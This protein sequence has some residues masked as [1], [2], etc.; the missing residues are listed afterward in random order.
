MKLVKLLPAVA[1]AIVLSACSTATKAGNAVVNGVESAGTAVVDGAKAAGNAVANGAEKVKETVIG[2]STYTVAYTCSA[3]GKK[4]PVT[5]TYAFEGDNP[6][7]ATVKLG[8]KVLAKNLKVNTEYQDG[9]QFTDG[10][11]VWSLSEKISP[12]TVSTV[13]PVMYVVKGKG[14]Q[15][16]DKIIAKDCAIV[17][18]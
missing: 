2:K 17:T 11:N 16:S 8:K 4:Q 10:K 18:K 12:T 7:T 5:A 14:T 1:A 13:E 9:V 6:Q 15:G 3:R